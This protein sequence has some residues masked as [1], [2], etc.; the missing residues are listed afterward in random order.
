MNR[1]D[2]HEWAM[3]VADA[4]S[5][6]GTCNS[7]NVGCVLLDADHRIVG[8]GYNGAPAGQPHC[9]EVGCNDDANGKCQN[10]VHAEE[11]AY[12]NAH[13]SLIG[14]T[15]YV[16]RKPCGYCRRLL[17]EIGVKE[18]YYRDEAGQIVR[19]EG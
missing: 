15:A 4:V 6:R 7:R 14:C 9:T 16:T 2:W 1:P 19:M 17:W 5:R 8:T 18:V 3:G 12:L 11:N 13:G 10:A